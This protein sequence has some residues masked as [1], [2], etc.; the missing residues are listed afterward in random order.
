[1]KMPNFSPPID[2]DRHRQRPDAVDA[3]PHSCGVVLARQHFD[4]VAPRH[5]GPGDHQGHPHQ[6]AGND[7]G[8]EEL[9][10][11]DVGNHAEDDHPDRRRDHRRDH[12]AGGNQRGR[13]RDVVVGPAHHR[14]QQRTDGRRVGRRA[15]GDGRHQY[16]GEDGHVAQAAPQVAHPGQRE[17]DDALGD[18]PGV[19]QLAGQQEEGNRQQREAVGALD[20]LLRHQGRVELPLTSASAPRRRGSARTRWAAPAPWAPAARA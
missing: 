18:A 4:L 5:P 14:N 19:H 8:Q 10:D 16:R 11:R 6:D 13:A 17:V 7:A 9:A 2:A 1:M 20:H 3:G 12:A 15:A